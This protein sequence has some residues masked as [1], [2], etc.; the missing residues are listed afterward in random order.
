MLWC[1]NLW[2]VLETC[3]PAK[4]QNRVTMSSYS[5]FLDL[6]YLGVW[7][8]YNHSMLTFILAWLFTFGE[9]AASHRCFE[10]WQYPIGLI[11]WH[12]IIHPITILLISAW[13]GMSKCCDYI[14][15][16]ERFPKVSAWARAYNWV[17]RAKYHWFVLY[18]WELW[19]RISN[20]DK[21]R[22]FG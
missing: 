17:F 14:S 16:N 9:S 12:V 21:H 3:F 20:G 13:I 5:I 4:E 8:S 15:V 11:L 18:G 19:P 22:N 6:L 10:I 2:L 7:F 1:A